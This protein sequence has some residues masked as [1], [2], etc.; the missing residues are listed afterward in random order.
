MRKFLI[1]F[2]VGVLLMVPVTAF[3]ASK[4][5]A[6]LYPNL[7]VTVDGK[8]VKLDSTPI[9]AE[10]RTYLPLRE[11]GEKVMGMEVNWD[12]DSQTVSL[13]SKIEEPQSSAELTDEQIRQQESFRKSLANRRAEFFEYEADLG[14]EEVKDLLRRIEIEIRME[15]EFLAAAEKANDPERFPPHL[16]VIVVEGLES[17]EQARDYWQ[18]RLAELKAQPTE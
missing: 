17:L 16:N 11:L 8:Q 12:Q 2:I 1:G 6:L 13:I 9:V 15:N 3:G 4:I 18:N 14:I 7:K 5:E 10:G